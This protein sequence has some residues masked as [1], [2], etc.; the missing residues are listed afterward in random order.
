MPKKPKLLKILRNDSWA[1]IFIG[2][3]IGLSIITL[4]AHAANMFTGMELSNIGEYLLILGVVF[5]F[6]L[7]VVPYRLKYVSD[8]FENGVEVKARVASKKVHRADLKLT[9]KYDFNGSNCEKVLDQLITSQT[10]HFLDESEVILI[11]DQYNPEHVLL[12]DVY[13]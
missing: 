13:Y 2:V 11:I 1:A 12:R 7:I 6:A 3:L 8:I 10:K 9:L 4:L 5:V